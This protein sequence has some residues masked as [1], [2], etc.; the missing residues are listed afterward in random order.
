MGIKALGK[1]P[2]EPLCKRPTSEL[3]N[4]QNIAVKIKKTE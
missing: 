1:E 2:I 3:I 4:R